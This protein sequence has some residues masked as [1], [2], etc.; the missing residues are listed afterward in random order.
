MHERVSVLFACLFFFLY[1]IFNLLLFNFV[2]QR[3]GFALVQLACVPVCLS[4]VCVCVCVC[5]CAR[6]RASERACHVC[7]AECLC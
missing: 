2:L 3:A 4:V 6:A 1:F 5:V 7:V